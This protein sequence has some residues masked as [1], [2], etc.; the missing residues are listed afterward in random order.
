VI[1]RA[2]DAALLRRDPY[3]YM[4]FARDGV[5]DGLVIVAAVHVV[6]MIPVIMDGVGVFPAARV[7]LT[8]L[9]NWI[10]LSGLVYLIGRHGLEG[11][12]SF[13]G[14]MAA[15]SIGFPVLLASLPLAFVVDPLT[16]QL[17]VSVWLVATLWMAA[18]V[19]LELPSERALVAALGGW[20]GFIIVSLIFAI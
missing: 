19:A 1:K 8:G 15:S 12:G 3:L 14:T 9:V 7:V 18:K 17:I 4:I 11:D 20:V 13:P 10:I 5:A 2:I 6:L 16:S